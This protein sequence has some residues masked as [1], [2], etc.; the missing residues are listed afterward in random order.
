MGQVLS[1]SELGNDAAIG[2]MDV[3][4]GSN[5]VRQDL[6]PVSDY[7]RRSFIARALDTENEHSRL[8][9]LHLATQP[10]GIKKNAKAQRGKGAKKKKQETREGIGDIRG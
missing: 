7:G 8:Q 4:L 1:R 3:V 6:A 9:T 10:E 2:T 5:E